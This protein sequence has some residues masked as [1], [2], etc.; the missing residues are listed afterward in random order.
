M[1]IQGVKWPQVRKGQHIPPS[2]NTM[3]PLHSLG[4]AGK[5]GRKEWH[6][7]SGI[8]RPQQQALVLMFPRLAVMHLGY[9]KMCKKNI[10]AYQIH[11]LIGFPLT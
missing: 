4:A 1:Q 3:G 11:I 8:P 2:T 7:P 6:S 5:G 9:W 10:Y